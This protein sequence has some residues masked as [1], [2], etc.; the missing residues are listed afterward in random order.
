MLIVNKA[1]PDYIKSL[2]DK[3]N[4]TYA[5][6]DATNPAEMEAVISKFTET[7]PRIDALICTVGVSNPVTPMD[8]FEKYKAIF[9]LN[10]F[11]NL[12][13]IKSLINRMMEARF[14]RIIVISST[15]GHI[16]PRSLTAYAPSK[17]ALDRMCRALQSEL[18]PFGISLDIVCPTTIKNKY[19]ETFDDKQ[20]IN[21]EE[22]AEKIVDIVNHPRNTTHFIPARFALADTIER[23]A[24]WFLDKKYGLNPKSVRD[25]VYK[26][27]EIETMLITDATSDIG[28]ELAYA[29]SGRLKKLYLLGDNKEMLSEV[30][31]N[32]RKQSGCE[33]E[34]ATPDLSNEK[35]I[36]DYARSIGPVDLLVNNRLS[37]V[38]G[39]IS[40]IPLD[41]Y[42][43]NFDANYL[44]FV[45]LFSELSR[46]AR[47]KK[48]ISIIASP[49]ANRG[50]SAYV[51]AEAALMAFTGSLRR[52]YG[53]D[54]QITEVLMSP[55]S[56]ILN[57]NGDGERQVRYPK[58]EIN[59]KRMKAGAIAN[60]IHSAENKGAERVFI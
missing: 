5:I 8:D 31:R 29:Y 55:S 10:F 28:K 52:E 47:P 7:H 37:P 57:G 27:A 32:V 1:R 18:Y 36:M 43:H 15:S 38:I 11:A 12:I 58:P 19:S 6:A 20:G 49:A 30:Q 23:F 48:V 45:A 21:A 24:P 53:N 3:K 33:V 26:K 14:G 59:R 60:R 39:G 4:V 56:L 25:Q 22:V 16:L 42:R 50:Y 35:S 41:V 2:A 34:I 40:D 9:E 13:P 46:K 54:V 51:S 44:G 17:W